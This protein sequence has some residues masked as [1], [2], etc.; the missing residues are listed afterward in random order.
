LEQQLA[1]TNT[2][3]TVQKI[4]KVPRT[5]CNR[6]KNRKKSTIIHATNQI[7]N[8]WQTHHAN[9]INAHNNNKNKSGIFIYDSQQDE[10]LP[11]R[12]NRLYL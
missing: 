11:L 7:Q 4:K 8:F 5:M 9:K 10:M 3:Y 12:E 6:K 1:Q 2:V